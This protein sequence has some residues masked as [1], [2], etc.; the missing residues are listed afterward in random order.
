VCLV[1]AAVVLCVVHGRIVLL[2]LIPI[3]DWVEV[4]GLVGVGIAAVGVIVEALAHLA[5]L[6]VNYA[7]LVEALIRVERRRLVE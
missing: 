6:H 7:R 2:W 4:L 5:P 3:V 1:V